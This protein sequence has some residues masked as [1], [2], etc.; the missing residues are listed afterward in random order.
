MTLSTRSWIRQAST[1]S[2]S[3]FFERARCALCRQCSDVPWK[4]SW[5]K[6]TSVG[7]S[8]IGARCGTLP[9]S[10]ANSLPAPRR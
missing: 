5:M 10:A 2:S 1:I 9:F 3:A 7:F 8:G 4:R 6:S